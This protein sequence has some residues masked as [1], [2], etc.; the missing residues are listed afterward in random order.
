MDTNVSCQGYRTD[1][2]YNPAYTEIAAGDFGCPATGAYGYTHQQLNSGNGWSFGGP[3]FSGG[4]VAP[5][6][7]MKLPRGTTCGFG[8]YYNS[9]LSGVCMG[10]AVWAG[11]CPPGWEFKTAKDDGGGNDAWFWCEYWYPNDLCPPGA[12]T[13]LLPSGAVC[14][15]TDTD[16][17]LSD[18]GVCEYEYTDDGCPYG[19]TRYGNY[20]RGRPAGHG[21]A[22]CVKN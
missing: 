17:S 12:C 10:M 6:D 7:E 15:V 11:I 2:S 8:N 14:G 1:T 9:G 19:Y 5:P 22:W 21:V 20:D 3:G 13:N 16:V 4:F 18:M